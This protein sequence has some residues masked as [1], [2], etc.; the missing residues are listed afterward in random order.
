MEPR[1]TKLKITVNGQQFSLRVAERI[2]KRN[3]FKDLE[4]LV[5]MGFESSTLPSVKNF[6]TL[7]DRK[8]KA[9]YNLVER[10]IELSQT[11]SVLF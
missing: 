7:L 2:L 11:T 10:T 5:R 8:M 9:A 6:S 3:S 4:E 1:S